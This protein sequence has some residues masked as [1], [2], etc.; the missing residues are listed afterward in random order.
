MR[1]KS[2][3]LKL[4]S[5]CGL[6]C[7]A[8]PSYNRGTCLGCRSEKKQQRKSKWTCKIRKCC[9]N[10][11][12]DYC[13]QCDKYPC[14]IINKKLICSHEDDPR[15]RYRHE[16][17]HNFETIERESLDTWLDFQKEKWRC[18]KCGGQIV[19]YNLIC[20]QCKQPISSITSNNQFII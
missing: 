9:I 10:K 2:K 17:P 12:T 1:K 6:Y 5:F 18:P 19:F 20:W 8:C 7:K 14:D 16:I 4:V 3:D 11:N 15:F 13:G